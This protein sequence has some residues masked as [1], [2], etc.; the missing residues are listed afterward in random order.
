MRWLVIAGILWPSFAWAEADVAT[1][2]KAIA[3]L[4]SQRNQAMDVAA[5]AEAQLAI[6]QEQIKALKEQLEKRDAK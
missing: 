3:V 6:A 5:S 1:L 4:Q 2:Q